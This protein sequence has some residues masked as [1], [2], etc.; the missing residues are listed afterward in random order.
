M[1]LVVLAV[2]PF[3]AV[4]RS[5][6][7]MVQ[8]RED[9]RFPPEAPYPL[10]IR[11][12]SRRQNLDRHLSPERCVRGAV[13]LAHPARAEERFDPIRPEQRARHDA[14]IA[15]QQVDDDRPDRAI[16][17]EGF[18]MLGFGEQRV[19]LIAQLSIARAR[20]LDECR[21]FARLLLEG[22]FE[23]LRHALPVFVHRR[24]MDLPYL[25][26]RNSGNERFKL[27]SEV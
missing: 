25:S 20:L 26:L 15:T 14:V 24:E 5:N 12:E 6:V 10:G 1:R 22:R 7:R 27:Q 11:G 18:G 21:S 4:D 13:Y 19:D 17:R 2:H 9:L 3:E 23:D 8:R 16:D